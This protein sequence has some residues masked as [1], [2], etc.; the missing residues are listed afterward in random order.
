MRTYKEKLDSLESNSV[1]VFTK[2]DTNFDEAFKA[3]TLFSEIKDKEHTNIEN[4]FTD[5]HKRYGINTDR[6]RMLVIPQMYGL[7]T[8]TPFFVR[9]GNY[10]DENPTEVFDHSK[11]LTIGSKEYN[12]FK[13]E[14]IGRAHV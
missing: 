14:Q 6:H 8:K 5:N 1:W 4:Y 12:V 10:A 7:I 3:A 11:S 13:T 2:Q 9:G